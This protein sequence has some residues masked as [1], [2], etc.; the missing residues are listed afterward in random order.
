[1]YLAPFDHDLAFLAHHAITIAFLLASLHLNLGGSACVIGLLL[2]EITSP[3]YHVY[4]CL[5]G[6]R[7]WHPTAENMFRWWAPLFTA[8]F[9][10]VR[11][12]CG[13]IASFWWCNKVLVMD[14]PLLHKSIWIICS[15]GICAVSQL[16][17]Y[18]FVKDTYQL[19][20]S[21]PLH[22]SSPAAGNGAAK[23]GERQARAGVAAVAA[24]TKSD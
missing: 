13:P 6:L 2:G 7:T 4:N 8:V 12:G 20:T 19:L 24:A 1:M 11:T 10:L 21:P 3:F 9:A 23:I 5:N 14:V 22:S 16:F 18:G 17:T 15:I